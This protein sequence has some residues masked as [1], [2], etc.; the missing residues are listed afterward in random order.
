MNLVQVRA[1]MQAKATELNFP[2]E[3]IEVSEYA[4]E[5]VDY[6]MATFIVMPA[7][8]TEPRKLAINMPLEGA[9]QLGPEGLADDMVPK[10]A[11]YAKPLLAV[12]Q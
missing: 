6:F 5:G 1:A 9:E 12:A 7:G 11:D 10:M 8:K 2:C 4:H 3:N